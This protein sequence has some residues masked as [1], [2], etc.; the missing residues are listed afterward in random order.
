MLKQPHAINNVGLGRA[1]PLRGRTGRRQRIALLE[2]DGRLIHASMASSFLNSHTN[3]RPA[4]PGGD[5][6]RARRHRRCEPHT[7]CGG[8]RCEPESH[9][10]RSRFGIAEGVSNPG[11]MPELGAGCERLVLPWDQTQPDSP[12]DF[13]KRSQTLNRTLLQAELGRGSRIAGLL[14]FTP[15]ELSPPPKCASA[16]S[17]RTW[18]FPMTIHAIISASTCIALLLS[19]KI[20]SATGLSGTSPSSDPRT[21]ARA[22]HSPGWGPMSNSR[23]S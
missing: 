4:G 15:T 10:P 12:D 1:L 2:V 6:G 21:T 7:R 9:I 5:Y 17:P 3:A 11:V 16:P 14:Q 19:T 8:W 23:N 22:A 18:T 13:S 20:R